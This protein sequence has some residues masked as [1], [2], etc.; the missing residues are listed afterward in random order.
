[1]AAPQSVV[2]PTAPPETRTDEATTPA[3]PTSLASVPSD[4]VA[5]DDAAATAS[6]G[7]QLLSRLNPLANGETR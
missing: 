3:A 2:V 6:L 7:A 4:E 1:G 5:A